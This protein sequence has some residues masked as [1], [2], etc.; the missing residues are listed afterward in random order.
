MATAFKFIPAPSVWSSPA[1]ERLHDALDAERNRAP[2]GS[3]PTDAQ[4]DYYNELGAAMEAAEELDTRLNNLGWLPT[5]RGS[6]DE[7][8]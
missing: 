4:W 2:M 1:L 7:V 5:Y 8:R 6:L 3:N